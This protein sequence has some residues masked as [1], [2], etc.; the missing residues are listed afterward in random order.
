MPRE[1][2]HAWDVESE[3][4]ARLL[5]MI[6]PGRLDTFLREFHAGTPVSEGKCGRHIRFDF[7][8]R[9]TADTIRRASK[10]SWY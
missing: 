3:G 5:M 8:C 9:M 10:E 6:V 2:P 1:V 4:E 7:F